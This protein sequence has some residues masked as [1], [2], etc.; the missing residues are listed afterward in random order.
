V[1]RPKVYLD[2]KRIQLPVKDFQGRELPSRTV[3]ELVVRVGRRKVASI[4]VF[5]DAS[6]V[7]ANGVAVVCLSD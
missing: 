2:R 1:S 3:E 4:K 6:S 5:Y 7:T